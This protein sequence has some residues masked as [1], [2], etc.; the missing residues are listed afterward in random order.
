MGSR[1]IDVAL[2]LA[3]AVGPEKPEPVWQHVQ[4]SALARSVGFAVA[5]V[6]AALSLLPILLLALFLR[7]ALFAALFDFFGLGRHRRVSL[8][9]TVYGGLGSSVGRAS[10][11][12][13]AVSDGR[14]ALAC[15]GLLAGGLLGGYLVDHLRQF[16]LAVFAVLLDAELRSY[17]VQVAQAL[18]FEGS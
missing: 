2:A 14:R 5:L 17:L 11:R 9:E 16:V 6:S 8:A 13:R 18:A 1:N 10:F 12:R 15:A 3:V 7:L 4:N